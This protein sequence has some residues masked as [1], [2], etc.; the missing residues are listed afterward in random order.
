MSLRAGRLLSVASNRLLAAEASKVLI[1]APAAGYFIRVF[2]LLA[3]CVT[4]AA[5]QIDVGKDGGT[6]LQQII[7]IPASGTVPVD[8]W[9]DAGFSMPEAIAL[10]AVPASTGPAWQFLIEYTIEQ[11]LV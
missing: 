7:S 4:A 5:Q 9:S 8:F 3:T 1:A 11:T 2:S 10:S 6:V